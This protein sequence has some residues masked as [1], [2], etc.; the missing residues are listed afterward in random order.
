[1]KH[2]FFLFIFY[3]TALHAFSQDS[4][5][6]LKHTALA[7]DLFIHLDRAPW[8]FSSMALKKPSFNIDNWQALP[9][10]DFNASRAPAGWKGIGWFS[11]WVKAD[12]MLAGKKL[13]IQI[14]HDG[15]SVIY[16]DG[17]PVG[18]YGRLG[19]SSQTMEAMRAPKS[20]IPLWLNDTLPHLITLHYAN[21]KPVFS[22]F[23]GFQ[24]AIGY[25]DVASQKINTGNYRMNFLLM[26]VGAH[27]ILGFLFLFLYIFYPTQKLNIYYAAFVLLLGITMLSIY[28]FYQTSVPQVQFYA[29]IATYVCKILMMW[30]GSLLLY[31]VGYVA[32]PRVRVITV[33]IISAVYILLDLVFVFFYNAYGW[34]DHFALI[35][36]LFTVDGFISVYQAAKRKLPGVWLIA[37][38]MAAIS[39]VYF[40]AW[41]DVF[42]LWPQRL[43]SMRLLVMA[44]GNLVFPACF[45][46]YLAFDYART[47]HNLSL[48]LKEIKLLYD[49]NLKQEAE[50]LEL[51]SGQA[52]KL[53]ATVKERTAEIQ[54]QADKLK[55]MDAVKS[56][57]F[58]NLTHEFKTPLTLII[59]PARELLAASNPV[60]VQT[61]ARLIQNNAERLLQL[62]NQLLDLSRLENGIME[63]VPEAVELVS[64]IK[65]QVK[66]YGPIALQKEIALL[67]GS[68]FSMLEGMVDKDKFRKILHNLLSNAVKFTETGRIEVTLNKPA[69]PAPGFEL[70]VKD[71]GSGIPPNK[72]PYIFERFYQADTNDTRSYE[73]SG[74][75]LSLA[76]EL[77]VLMGGTITAES[78]EN[79]GTT[80]TVSLPCAIISA[81]PAQHFLWEDMGMAEKI[82]DDMPENTVTTTPGKDLVLV[83]EDNK[84]LRDF[85]CHTLSTSY[86]VISAADGKTGM[87]MALEQIPDIVITDIM[88]PGA[89]GYQ[90]CSRLK[91]DARTS[92]IPVVFLTAK[93]G[94]E[95]RVQGIE[96][97]ADAYLEKPFSQQ[98]L[99]ATIQNLIA[100]R[101]LLQKKYGSAL[102]FT[103]ETKL[104]SIEQDFINR[105]QSFIKEN[106]DNPQFGA[107]QLASL[108]A[109]SRSQLHRKLKG[110]LDKSAGELIRTAR[111]EHAHYLL[112]NNA[113]TIA[114]VAYTVGFSAPSAFTTAFSRYFGYPPGETNL[115]TTSV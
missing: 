6:Q 30:A 32:M 85:L 12:F 62:I 89:D 33:S 81:M 98:E 8:R 11:L 3:C 78:K 41:G 52:K 58:T 66:L 90:V 77:V 100:L 114:E 73:G 93:S 106:L 29:E 64:E 23:P 61:N 82:Q 36:F 56:R 76:K 44:I 15:A 9:G 51:V 69:A 10:T 47:N 14:N 59:S 94:T 99:H 80:I 101:S 28:F 54:Q 95:N 26:T 2:L 50:K 31:A 43:N 45:S 24:L 5:I 18:S 39:L 74:I 57:F 91:T 88:M 87:D 46:F 110:L 68:D 75:G 25:Y 42:G 113:A 63:I 22:N 70:T 71:T 49:Q 21:Y 19:I 20:L 1:M 16:V 65:E 60:F 79:A 109:L 34:N 102:P 115:H 53:E 55:E 38:G 7:N 84:E 111:M 37:T 96:T 67:S 72:L 105:M 83:I 86:N 108:M 97:G 48:K 17:R 35:F 27:F 103:I 92:H 104:P 13:A 107:D 40:F 4:V 112:K